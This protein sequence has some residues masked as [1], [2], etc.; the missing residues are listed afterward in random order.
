MRVVA[1]DGRAHPYAR[2]LGVERDRPN[3]DY[4]TADIINRVGIHP[5]RTMID[6]HNT[7][8]E[9]PI[10]MTGRLR[11]TSQGGWLVDGW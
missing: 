5:F 1:R 3:E 2:Q 11:L 4:A 9:V 8:L 7:A 6:S 10:D